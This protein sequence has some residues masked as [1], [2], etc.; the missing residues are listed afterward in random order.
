M[1]N[2]KIKMILMLFMCFN[3]YVSNC[4]SVFANNDVA[5]YAN[6]CSNCGKMGMHVSNRTDQSIS[7]VKC[8]H[9]KKG[10]DQRIFAIT[11][12]VWNCYECGHGFEL[13]IGNELIK[14]QCIPLPQ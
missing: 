4:I 5:T 3:F 12:Q 10:I 1:K 14:V 7:E 8:V 13:I 11:F 2:N 9:G 6:E